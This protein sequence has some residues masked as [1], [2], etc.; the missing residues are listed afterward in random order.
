MFSPKSLEAQS[1]TTSATASVSAATLWADH[2]T[3]VLTSIERCGSGGKANT[4]HRRHSQHHTLRISSSQYHKK[5]S[6]DPDMS[7]SLNPSPKLRIGLISEKA[8][9]CQVSLLFP[10]KKSSNYQQCGNYNPSLKLRI[11]LMKKIFLC[12]LALSL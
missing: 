11:G 12:Q 5:Y 9:L 4:T 2:R 3:E 7:P 1:R 10:F 8:L 6:S